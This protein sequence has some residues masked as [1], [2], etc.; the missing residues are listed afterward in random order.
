MT[1][2][3]IITLNNN[4]VR[5]FLD[6]KARSEIIR[7]DEF[8]GFHDDG[9]ENNET[10]MNAILPDEAFGLL[11][12]EELEMRARAALGGE[13]VERARAFAEIQSGESSH[14][15]GPVSGAGKSRVFA[16]AA[17]IAA[18][19][20]A[21]TFWFS[22]QVDGLS[23]LMLVATSDATQVI[24][25]DQPMPS[26]TERDT[27]GS[28]HESGAA[29]GDGDALIG[30]NKADF[31]L[32]IFRDL[33]GTGQIRDED[34]GGGWTGYV[35]LDDM[36]TKLFL[37]RLTDDADVVYKAGRKLSL[38]GNQ[39]TAITRSIERSEYINPKRMRVGDEIYGYM[40]KGNNGLHYAN[41]FYVPKHPS[42][43]LNYWGIDVQTACKTPVVISSDDELSPQFGEF[44]KEIGNLEQINPCTSGDPSAVASIGG[45]LVIKASAKD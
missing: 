27:A 6:K 43:M 26:A 20:I 16:I 32:T 3:K 2:E 11:P 1:R 42:R 12:L 40:E 44:L 5:P 28:Q 17:C 9:E 19:A 34:S 14:S 4:A 36:Q 38:S 33:M 35:E 8:W 41:L 18:F 13:V 24:S 30:P 7:I 31:I 25:D 22:P 15:G 45:G 21:L 29:D 23:N 37:I 10:E 39:L